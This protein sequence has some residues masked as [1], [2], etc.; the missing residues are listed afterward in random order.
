[1]RGQRVLSPSRAKVVTAVKWP[2]GAEAGE[3]TRFCNSALLRPSS[4]PIR[5][6]RP[7]P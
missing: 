3:K 7:R 5:V 1:M 6:G 2:D 4:P